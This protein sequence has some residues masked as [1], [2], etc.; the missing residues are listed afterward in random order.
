MTYYQRKFIIAIALAAIITLVCSGCYPKRVGPVGPDGKKLTWPEMDIEQRKVHMGKVVLPL[1]RVVFSDWRPERFKRV[2]C[3]LCHGQGAKIGN[4]HMPTNHL[5]R[6]SGE[7]LLRPEFEKHPNTT[8]LKLNRLVPE[9]AKALGLKQFSLITRSGFGCY[10]CPLVQ[11]VP[12]LGTE[13]DTFIVN[14]HSGS[15]FFWNNEYNNRKKR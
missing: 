11:P 1:A 10:S 3:T 6:L 15:W 5:P 2:D 8:R 7:F 12:C 9:M 13:G 4:F 14:L